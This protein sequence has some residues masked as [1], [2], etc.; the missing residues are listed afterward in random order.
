ME[1][2]NH[3]VGMLSFV[4]YQLLLEHGWLFVFQLRYHLDKLLHMGRHTVLHNRLSVSNLLQAVCGVVRILCHC[5]A[6]PQLG[7]CYFP[8]LHHRDQQLHI[9]SFSSRRVASLLDFGML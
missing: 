7:F 6:A 8:S 3:N 5:Q 9:N 4:F 2:K 1:H